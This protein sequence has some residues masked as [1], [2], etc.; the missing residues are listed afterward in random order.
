MSVL[1]AVFEIISVDFEFSA[2]RGHRPKVLCLAAREH[3]SGRRY[4]IA[5]DELLRMKSPPFDIGPRTIIVGYFLS[6]EM[7]CF[8]EL[9]WPCPANLLDLFVEF[10]NQL[11]GHKLPLGFKLQSCL[12]YFG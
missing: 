11:N 5:R 8:L 6:A 10:R 4:S 3:R 12:Q 7:D 2:P 1:D 9:G